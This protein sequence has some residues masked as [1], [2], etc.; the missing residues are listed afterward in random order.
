MPSRMLEQTQKSPGGMPTTDVMGA[1]LTDVLQR[2]TRLL[3]EEFCSPAQ[4]S[5]NDEHKRPQSSL[6]LKRPRDEDHLGASLLVDETKPTAS[7]QMLTEA[8]WDV[9][10]YPVSELRPYLANSTRLGTPPTSD[11][12]GEVRG[13]EASARHK[14]EIL[15]AYVKCRVAELPMR[16]QMEAL[17]MRRHEHL[18]RAH[19]KEIVQLSEF[20]SFQQIKHPPQMKDVLQGADREDATLQCLTSRSEAIRRVRRA[21]ERVVELERCISVDCLQKIRCAGRMLLLSAL[22]EHLVG[23]IRDFSEDDDN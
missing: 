17:Q 1:S 20:L 11:S 19:M 4:H 2:I 5:S 23:A 16:L 13:S 22:T 21:Q 12:S 14:R 3:R 9:V 7:L 10:L 18:V 6:S 15:V 8:D